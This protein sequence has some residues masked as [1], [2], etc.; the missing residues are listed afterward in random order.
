[1]NQEF[2]HIHIFR[3][4]GDCTKKRS[5]PIL[6]KGGEKGGGR[7]ISV[8]EASVNSSSAARERPHTHTERNLVV[9][10]DGIPSIQDVLDDGA[11]G[12]VDGDT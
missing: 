10:L 6:R 5:V 1:M 4:I 11:A 8:A 2:H 9:E 12:V 3:I 7:G